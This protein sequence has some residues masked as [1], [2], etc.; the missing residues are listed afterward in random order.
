[1]SPSNSGSRCEGADVPHFRIRRRQSAARRVH[2]SGR[3]GERRNASLLILTRATHSATHGAPYHVDILAMFHADDFIPAQMRA[4]IHTRTSCA[5][6]TPP[7][8]QDKTVLS[9]SCPV[10]RF[11]RVQTSNFLSARVSSCRESNSHRGSGR[12]TDKTVLSCL[13]WWC[14]LAFRV[15]AHGKREPVCATRERAPF[16]DG[17]R[18]R[19][20]TAW[21]VNTA[22]EQGLNHVL[23]FNYRII[24]NFLRHI[25]SHNNT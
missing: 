7:A 6:F 17:L 24:Y 2:R 23:T 10:C 9:V 11:E 1:V 20:S 21:H 15:D 18:S 4:T 25:G 22:C 8:R 16:L 12:D 19:T 13:A 5:Q 14:E 3:V